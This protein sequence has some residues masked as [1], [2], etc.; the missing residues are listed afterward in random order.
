MAYLPIRGSDQAKYVTFSLGLESQFFLD[1]DQFLNIIV[2]VVYS[3][4]KHNFDLKHYEWKKWN[5]DR[6]HP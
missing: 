3:L 1:N 2:V 4:N 5:W 6:S